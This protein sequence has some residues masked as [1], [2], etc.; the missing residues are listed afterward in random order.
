MVYQEA[1]QLLEYMERFRSKVNNLNTSPTG[2]LS[3]ALSDTLSLDERCRIPQVLKLFGEQAPNVELVVD[4]MH[5]GDMERMVLNDELDVAYIPYHRQLAGLN[6]IHL[7]TDNNYLYCGRENPLYAMPPDTITEQ[8]I[9]SA[10]LVHAGLKPHQEV[11][12]NLASMNLAGTSYHYESRI[13]MM[14]SGRFVG[15]LPEA[16]AKPHVESGDLKAIATGLK[17]FPLGVAV[18]TRKSSHQ[19][20]AK[21][22]FLNAIEVAFSDVSAEAPY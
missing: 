19:N 16:V 13:A 6:Y 14:L 3:V 11:Y 22:M 7:F 12:H 18:I 17:S 1:T 15:F 2:E 9:N 5:M 21:E 10:P 8:M 4:V 20:R